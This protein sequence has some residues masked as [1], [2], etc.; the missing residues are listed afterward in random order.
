M[1]TIASEL[2][3]RWTRNQ[4]PRRC[5]CPTAHATNLPEG[6]TAIPLTKPGSGTESTCATALASSSQCQKRSWPSHEPEMA[7]SEN[8]GDASAV[9]QHGPAARG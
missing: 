7:T 6:A 3:A 4:R 2:R 1:G 8:G 5:S 9:T